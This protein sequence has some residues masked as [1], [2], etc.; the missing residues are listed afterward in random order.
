[1]TRLRTVAIGSSVCLAAYVSIAALMFVS[2][3]RI[4][5]QPFGRHLS[6]SE[7]GLSGFEDVV[8]ATADGERLAA[9]WKRAQPSRATIVYFH[10]NGG[11]AGGR[12]PRALALAEGGR[13]VLLVEYRGY[14]GSTGSPS[15]QGFALDADAADAFARANAGGPVVLY[16]ESLGSA[17]AVALAARSRPAA[18]ILDAPFTSMTDLARSRY[19][20]LPV[21]VL[22]LDRFDSVSAIARTESP[23]TILHGTRDDVVPTRMG[24]ALFAAAR[25][26]RRLVILDGSDHGG[27]LETAAG[28]EAVSTAI[29]E[30]ETN[31]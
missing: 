28:W 19:G 9:Y 18:L 5:Y 14:P 6:A 1:M 20:W 23:T 12:A 7:A 26:P 11:A 3:R 27:N 25:N 30:A 13:G 15:E 22:L 10:G 2:Q 17:V 8:L 31:R 4:M 24:K 29:E 21:D 16:G